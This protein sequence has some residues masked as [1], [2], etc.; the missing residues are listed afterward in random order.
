MY[1]Y[2]LGWDEN[3]ENESE[4]EKIEYPL[5]NTN[6]NNYDDNGIHKYDKNALPKGT[7]VPKKIIRGKDFKKR[8][9]VKKNWVRDMFF[10]QDYPTP[11][12]EEGE[13]FDRYLEINKDKIDHWLRD[14]IKSSKIKEAMFKFAVCCSYRKPD[15]NYDFGDRYYIYSDEVRAKCDMQ[16][17]FM[18]QDKLIES[19]TARIEHSHQI[20]SGLTTN[21]LHYIRCAFT[22]FQN[23]K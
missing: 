7:I 13:S 12:F 20:A 16:G 9:R 3:F 18:G 21:K 10:D 8:E 6:D 15:K 14:Q 5:F 19:L 17:Y 23:Y 22:V 11:D 1:G 4:E 2:V